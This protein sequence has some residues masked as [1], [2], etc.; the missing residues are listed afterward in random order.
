MSTE[1]EKPDRYCLS[2]GLNFF[3]Q[4]VAALAMLSIQ[5]LSKII[6]VLERIVGALKVAE[7]STLSDLKKAVSDC[8]HGMEILQCMIEKGAL[9]IAA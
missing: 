7:K 1:A 6:P 2:S 9:T 3:E 4:V 5:D 8:P